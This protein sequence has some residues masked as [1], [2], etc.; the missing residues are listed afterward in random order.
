MLPGIKIGLNNWKKIVSNYKPLACEVWFRIDWADRYQEM[1]SH[2]VKEQIPTGLHFWG[3]LPEGVMP[4]FAFPDPNIRNSS[5]LLVKNTIDIAAENNFRYVN[6][7]P[8]SYQL[9]KINLDRSYFRPIK[10]KETTHS[11]GNKILLENINELHEYAMK[12]NVLLTVETVPSRE[13]LHWRDFTKGRLHTQNVKNVP[14]SVVEKLAKKGFYICNDICHTA[15]DEISDDR[16]FLFDTLFNKSKRL[17]S[18]TKLVH[19]NTMIPPFNGTDAHFGLRKEDFENNVFPSRDQFKKLLYLFLNRKDV[20]LI[21][22]P[23]SHHIENTKALIKLL[24]E[25]REER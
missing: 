24:E 9:T 1:F 8:G 15:M 25:I 14:V 21:P 4:N 13:P 16:N 7:H 19:V 17:S 2:L 11:T 5:I 6:I 23:Y 22:E 3:M 10:G 12:R 20:W 18:Q